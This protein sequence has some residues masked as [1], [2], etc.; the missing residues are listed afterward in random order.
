MDFKVLSK[1]SFTDDLVQIL[2]WLAS[3]NPRAARNS[4]NLIVDRYESL[5]FFP[6]RHPR[7]V[8][9]VKFGGSWWI[10]S[11]ASLLSWIRCHHTSGCEVLSK[12]NE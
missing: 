5:S 2:R 4:G 1:E 7:F 8:N 9:D 6:K 10:R 11:L 12:I 3:E